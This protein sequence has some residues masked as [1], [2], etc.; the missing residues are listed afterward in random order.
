MKMPLL[1]R[2]SLSGV[3]LLLAFLLVA[4]D[5]A[6]KE[7]PVL[8]LQGETMG[9]TWHVTVPGI[10]TE[11]KVSSLQA[12]I[13]SVLKQVNA[14]MS[15]WQSDSELS[16]FN[17]H[18]G[19]DWFPVS[20]ELVKVVT[21]A[22]EIS[23]L[24]G[25]V[26]DITVG[27]LVNLWGF[28]PS[29][30]EQTTPS[31]A[32]IQATLARVGYSQLEV[33]QRPSALRK[34]LPELY[35]DLSSIAKGFGADR[36]ALFLDEQGLADYLVEI[37]GEIRAKGL[38]QR[39]DV[40]RIAIEKPMDLGRAVQQG[41]QLKDQGL[42]T[43]GDYRNFFTENG[44][45]YSHTL[46]PLTGNPVQHSLASVSVAAS[47]TMTA[48]AY[49]TLLMALGDERGREF[50]DQHQLNAFFIIRTDKGFETYATEGF[51]PLLI[52]ADS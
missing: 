43:S 48:D 28:G 16:L 25:G 51:K 6:E 18:Q 35:V 49:A 46:N 42:A 39:G 34:R 19:T 40:W 1:R 14:Q 44:K 4:C 5:A 26:Y 21:A 7:L 17:Q 2:C 29:E 47:D 24:S 36:V 3:V 30:H 41:I 45:R 38:S 31:E 33:R 10:N 20:S 37:G 13:T 8:R 11:D 27:P 23:A 52:A 12:G 50:A 9:T 22:Q 15:T 32:E